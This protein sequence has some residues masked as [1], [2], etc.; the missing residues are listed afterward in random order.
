MTWNVRLLT[1]VRNFLENNL[2]GQVINLNK[3]RKQKARKEK[4]VQAAHN[5]I[6]HGQLKTTKLKSEKLA[7]KDQRDL[8]GKILA[9]PPSTID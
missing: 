2:V 4:E 5:R 1:L 9:D 3:I 7:K 8:D 6:T